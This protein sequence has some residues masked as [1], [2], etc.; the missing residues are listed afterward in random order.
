VVSL[1]DQIAA[2]RCD[3]GHFGSIMIRGHD[4]RDLGWLRTVPG[5]ARISGMESSTTGC[6][7]WARDR[8]T[9]TAPAAPAG[10]T[11]ATARCCGATCAS[12]ETGSSSGGGRGVRGGAPRQRG[13]VLVQAEGPA[14]ADPSL[15]D[16]S[17]PY[18]YDDPAPGVDVRS[19]DAK[20]DPAGRL[21]F[22]TLS[23]DL[24]TPRVPCTGSTRAPPGR[25]GCCRTSP[26]PTASAGPGPECTMWTRSRI[27]STYLTTMR[28]RVRFGP[29]AVRVA[30]PYPDGL[31]VDAE[32]CVWV[33]MFNEAGGPPV[34]PDGALDRELTVPTPQTT[35]CAFVGSRL[36]HPDHHHRRRGPGQGHPGRRPHVRSDLHRRQGPP[37]RPLRRLILV[38]VDLPPPRGR[39][40][41]SPRSRLEVEGGR[42]GPGQRRLLGGLGE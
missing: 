23:R 8:T 28:D 17:P 35:S 37:A 10:S 34:H 31:C 15:R 30:A 33:A 11:S 41:P 6:A 19:N 5:L 40:S 24:S 21:W 7:G 14:L 27:K 13:F 9:T 18:P 38:W 20:A 22:G 42:D 25:C 26:S 32:G 1:A 4:R 2:I 39:R 12:G 3:S 29:A 16:A 36:R